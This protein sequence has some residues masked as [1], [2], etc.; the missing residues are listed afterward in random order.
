[1]GLHAL[2]T[3]GHAPGHLCL[4]HQASRALICGDM[5]ANGSTIIVDPPEGN[6]GQYLASLQRLK[7]LPAGTLYP[8]HGAPM[9]DGVGK[10]D[11]YLAHR[12]ARIEALHGALGKQSKSVADLVEQVY[13]DVDPAIWPIAQR[14]AQASLEYL[15]EEGRARQ[16]GDGFVRI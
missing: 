16:V 13:A 7:D 11:Q 2:H 9:A 4:L 1:M 8:A 6:M 12:F 5:V 15:V 14:S 10:L 3:P